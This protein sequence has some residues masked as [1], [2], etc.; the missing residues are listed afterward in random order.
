MLCGLNYRRKRNIK[1][2][3][4]SESLSADLIYA[5]TNGKVKPSKQ[6]ALGMTV[7]SL[8]N[9]RKL[10]NILN[11]YGH[12]CS[13]TVLEEL[14]TEAT[15]FSTNQSDICPEDTLQSTNFCT[16]LA[17]NNF[18]RFVDTLSG[19][20]TLHDTV[21][22][23][24]QNKYDP[25]IDGRI[26]INPDN[27]QEVLSTE[28]SKKRRRAFD[29]VTF[30]LEAYAK[31][32]RLI[33]IL[34]PLDHPERFIDP[35]NLQLFQKINFTWIF[36]HLLK[37]PDIPMWVGY[38]S[39][40]FDDKSREQQVSYLTTINDSP[41]NNSVVVET[42]K[43][44]QR[45]ANECGEIYMQVT[46]D[47][48]IAKVAL[49]IQRT[50]KPRFDNLFIHVGMFH[51]MMAYFKAI[52][53][54]INNCG[55]S[56]VMI[57][58]DLLASGSINGFLEGKHFNR[59]R[60]L[61]PIIYLAINILHFESF[62]D[63][64]NIEITDQVKKYL[65]DFIKH[66]SERP[67]VQN[68]ELENLF[69]EYDDY[70]QKTLQ[71]EHGKTPQFYLMYAQLIEYFFILNMSIRKG[72]FELFKFIL[73]KIANIFFIFNQQNYSRY[74]VKYHDNLIKIDE[75]HPDLRVQLEK[76]SFGIKRTKKPFSRQP[77]DLTLEQTINADAANK[78]TGIVNTTNSI[79]ARQRWCKS[80]SIR[81]T[82]IS[83]VMDK[84][85][86]RT[87]QDVT[88]DLQKSSIQI[89]S[90][91]LKKL[92]NSIQQNINPFAP[93]LQRNLLFNIS[94]GQA[95]Q[96][97]VADFLLN[98]EKNG[99]NQREDFIKECSES[100]ERFEKVIKKNKIMNFASSLIKKKVS[101]SS[102]VVEVSIHRDLF[103]Q[104]FRISLQKT[105]DIAKV[106]SFPLTPVPF[107]LC[108]VDGSICKT[109]K[110]AL[111]KILENKISTD[112]PQNVD[113]IIFDG[114]FLLHLM[115]DIPL[116]LGGVSQKFLKMC[117]MSNAHTVIINFDQYFSP[118]IKDNEH[119]LRGTTEDYVFLIKGPDQRCPVNFNVELKNINFKKA[120]VNFFI[121]DWENSYMA[122]FIGNKTIY[123]NFDYCY[124]YEVHDGKVNKTLDDNLSCPDHEEADTKII[125]NVCK[126][127]FD[128]NVVIRCSDTDILVIMLGNM[129]FIKKLKLWMHVGVGNAQRYI[130]VS[131]LHET[132]G[133]KLCN[134]LPA[135]HALT[136]CDFN[137]SFYRKGKT[138]PL[139][140]FENS[141][142]YI[143]AFKKISDIKNGN[144]EEV[145]AIL[146]EFVCRI[147]GLKTC[148]D[149]NEARV[150]VFMKT[151]KFTDNDAIFRSKMKNIDGSTALQIRIPTTSKA[152]F[153]HRKSLEKCPSSTANRIFT[154]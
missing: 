104:L 61:H 71:G 4:L 54:F 19:K 86:L 98:I 43:Q 68:R 65:Q 6:I 101:V 67:T 66:R 135:F 29:E 119:L 14:E 139:T 134:A 58:S 153:L 147:Y 34:Q 11:R 42:M 129:C 90:S 20:G 108:H 26:E 63:S 146:E 38:N 8:T 137:P 9:S 92:I 143:D 152:H 2:E 109:D 110:S 16:G 141:E 36:S 133:E 116:N 79:S 102:K 131:K 41:T 103:G 115:R 124:K 113:V 118:S 112:H 30:E 76:G 150:L 35:N 27:S 31:K 5:V 85:G 123:L 51:V 22:I 44:S 64:E 88:A 7:K 105:L 46:Y 136:G 99:N 25:A 80:H 151:Y 89:N 13:Y 53:K 138:R 77:V 40:I 18:D 57:N 50:E 154:T 3:R 87:R 74:L 33:E 127:D 117:V 15:Y 121:T 28:K 145:Y 17:F 72:D 37:L 60:R 12:C 125:Y 142:K 128:A 39:L 107:S 48:A 55:I 62:A 130:N 111:L 59:C 56:T 126:I 95:A 81:T 70:K 23:I 69:D 97:H 24:F 96:E 82:I 10:V 93:D 144:T 140:L 100:E 149:L 47:L 106:L 75:T 94:T 52:G 84:A 21:G 1:T 49:Q 148:N 114:F 120:L 83:H 45:V 91:H 32:P 122:L 73:P 78:L 132:L